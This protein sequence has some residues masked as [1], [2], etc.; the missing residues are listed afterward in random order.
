MRQVEVTRAVIRLR[1]GVQETG[2]RGGLG[3]D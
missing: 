3:Y 2:E 1:R